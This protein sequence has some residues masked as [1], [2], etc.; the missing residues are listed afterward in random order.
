LDVEPVQYFFNLISLALVVMDLIEIYCKPNLL[1]AV[2]DMLSDRCGQFAHDLFV[3][4]FEDK[5]LLQFIVHQF[6]LIDG[7]Y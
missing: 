3:L 5:S 6:I 4:I 7:E 1:I 2:V